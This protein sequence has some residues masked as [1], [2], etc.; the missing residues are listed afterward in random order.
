MAYQKKFTTKTTLAKEIGWPARLL[1]EMIGPPDY[2]MANPN[3]IYGQMAMYNIE[4][5]KLF[6]DSPE[7]AWRRQ[8][9]TRRII[10]PK[11][12]ELSAW[13]TGNIV[14]EK[15]TM[16]WCVQQAEQGNTEE[17][18]SVARHLG[19]D[20]RDAFY[21]MAR[22]SLDGHVLRK[23]IRE[24]RLDG[25][26]WQ[27]HIIRAMRTGKVVE[28][29]LIGSR[30]ELRSLGDALHL[31][32]VYKKMPMLIFQKLSRGYG[33]RKEHSAIVGR[34][35]CSMVSGGKAWQ[36]SFLP[37]VEISNEDRNKLFE[38]FIHRTQKDIGEEESETLLIWAR[39]RWKD[40]D[41]MAALAAAA[42]ELRGGM[43]TRNVSNFTKLFEKLASEMP[44]FEKDDI[45]KIK[46]Y[47]RTNDDMRAGNF[48]ASV[49]RARLLNSENVSDNPPETVKKHRPLM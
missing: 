38:N 26:A 48:R 30:P 45:K 49:L 4:Q 24:L 20:Y 43:H 7:V 9:K 27:R 13:K 31:E 33:W 10:K 40:Q 46:K 42:N 35:A 17:A 15:E 29:L 11:P 44:E 32:A 37:M 25:L 19:H 5:A 1:K 3:P 12:E 47:V 34:M 16:R 22:E 41:I 8:R 2:Y 28:T 14:D 39:S 18:I 23:S 36:L 6:V 21:G